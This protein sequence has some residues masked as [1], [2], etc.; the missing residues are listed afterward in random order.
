M[1][2][3]PRLYLGGA[4]IK[5]VSQKTQILLLTLLSLSVWPWTSSFPSLGLSFPIC[6]KRLGSV[7]PNPFARAVLRS[8]T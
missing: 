1:Q 7:A 8:G 2:I 3:K 6:K 4:Q 5:G